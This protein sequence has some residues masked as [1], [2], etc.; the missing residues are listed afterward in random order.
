M[1]RPTPALNAAILTWK[2]GFPIPVDLWAKLTDQGFDVA[3]L[4]RRHLV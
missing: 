2:R 1:I 4:E 3:S